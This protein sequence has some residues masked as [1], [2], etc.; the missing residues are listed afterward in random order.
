MA[1]N[2]RRRDRDEVDSEFTD[3]LVLINRVAKVVKGGR[4]YSFN[5]VVVDGDGK[6][7]NYED[8]KGVRQRGQAK[9]AWEAI[10]ETVEADGIA[11]A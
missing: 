5:A 8:A 2:D 4:R 11:A 9:R 7:A 6:M 3:R 1:Q 10:W